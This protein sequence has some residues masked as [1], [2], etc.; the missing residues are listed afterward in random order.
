MGWVDDYLGRNASESV[1]DFI[2]SP[3]KAIILLR[4]IGFSVP[5]VKPTDLTPKRD[6]RWALLKDL[7][8]RVQAAGS[9][10]APWSAIS[11]RTTRTASFNAQ[12]GVPERRTLELTVDYQM[13]FRA[14]VSA[15]RPAWTAFYK[16]GFLHRSR[17]LGE[18]N[19]ALLR[20]VCID[21]PPGTSAKQWLQS[22]NRKWKSR[23]TWQFK[24]VRGLVTELHRAEAQLTGRR[25]GLA[26]F[27][28][29]HARLTTQEL[30]ELAERDNHAARVRDRRL[31]A[32][33]DSISA[34][35]I[36]VVKEHAVEEGDVAMPPKT[37]KH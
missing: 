21:C 3:T 22:W 15:L 2:A 19:V 31:V 23:A 11:A 18:R 13:S 32:G 8:A 28:D 37:R 30:N 17:A 4:A 29:P 7:D 5:I 6:R 24:D 33:F 20:H 14:F 27:Y 12:G 35:G 26:W 1:G 10:A 16:K 9:D 34:A 25:H 36:N